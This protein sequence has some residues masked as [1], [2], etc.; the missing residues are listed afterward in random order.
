MTKFASLKGQLLIAMPGIQGDDFARSVVFLCEHSSE[1]AMGL[2]INKPLPDMIFADLVDKLDMRQKDKQIEDEILLRLVFN[3]GPVKRFQGFVLHSADYNSKGETLKI[4]KDFGL[5]ATVTVL[6]EIALGAGPSRHLVALGYAGWG[7]GQ[8]ESEIM[9]NGW[10]N[11]EADFELVFGTAHLN[12]HAAALRKL[13][14]DRRMLS[15]ET[16]HA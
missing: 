8:L 2:V 4:S 3:G 9:R 12:L 13:G 16:G 14:V 6:R 1:G 5:T 11:C 7:A 15:S 10:L